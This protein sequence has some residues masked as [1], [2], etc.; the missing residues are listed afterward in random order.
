MVNINEIEP[1]NPCN[2]VSNAVKV[3]SFLAHCKRVCRGIR[4]LVDS[5]GGREGRDAS[6]SENKRTPSVN[7]AMSSST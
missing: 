2:L 6:I 5:G 3:L 4:G 1:L 7:T